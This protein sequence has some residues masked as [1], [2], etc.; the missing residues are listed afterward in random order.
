[1][2]KPTS[3]SKIQ[4]APAVPSFGAPFLPP[5]PTTDALVSR[6]TANATAP[7][8]QLGLI[9]QDYDSEESEHEVDEEA[10]FANLQNGPYD[11]KHP[12][13][14]QKLANCDI[15]L[16][17]EFN[18]ELSTLNS[19]AD[20]ASWIEERKKRW[21]SKQRIEEKKQEVQSRMQ[22]RR[23]IEEETR[24]AAASSSNGPAS[25]NRVEPPKHRQKQQKIRPQVPDL[26]EP[27]THE[28]KTTKPTLEE[29]RRE[30]EKQMQKVQ[31]LQ[32]RLAESESKAA[33]AA[34]TDAKKKVL[35]KS[36][37]VIESEKHIGNTIKEKDVTESLLAA[38]EKTPSGLSPS[39]T[40]LHPTRFGLVREI[41]TLQADNG[42][43]QKTEYNDSI[44]GPADVVA[45]GASDSES[46]SSSDS[47]SSDSESDSDGAPEEASSKT[48]K[49]PRVPPPASAQRVCSAFANTGRCKFGAKCRYRHVH[50]GTG[51]QPHGPR[52]SGTSKRKSLYQRMVE[53]EQEEENKLA[54]QAIKH[55][56]SVGFF[57]KR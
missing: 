3:V 51:P 31:E 11:S 32:R 53:Q 38:L 25:S 57:S 52:E 15:R 50:D 47:S 16:S 34:G 54:L 23:R 55:L 36:D 27:H 44:H 49:P 28:S 17:F 40:G 5:K 24:A 37:P 56:G 2:K 14:H 21:P 45:K 9:P 4:A 29:T 33:A 46:D 30:L 10:A 26:Q 18:G 43:V 19:S 6:P 20:I 39:N 48:D 13:T 42:S 12:K 1:M 7:K 41:E 35:Q 8:K 22:E